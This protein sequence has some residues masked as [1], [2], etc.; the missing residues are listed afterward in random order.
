MAC[1]ACPRRPFIP[2][3][4]A[5]QGPRWKRGALIIL[6]AK[7][8]SPHQ[9]EHLPWPLA[10]PAECIAARGPGLRQWAGMQLLGRLKQ[11]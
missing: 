7:A 5:I 3:Q 6:P 8:P 1:V 4:V 10:G 9:D 2:S 11:R